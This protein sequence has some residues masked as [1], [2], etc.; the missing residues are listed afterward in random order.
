MRPLCSAVLECITRWAHQSVAREALQNPLEVR[1]CLGELAERSAR[2]C[3]PMQGLDVIG[4]QKQRRVRTRL[5]DRWTPNEGSSLTRLLEARNAFFRSSQ[6][7][8]HSA[9][10]STSVV[11]S[12]DRNATSFGAAALPGR[13][14][15]ARRAGRAR[16]ACW[17]A[18]ALRYAA[19]RLANTAALEGS[20]S[21]LRL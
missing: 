5:L 17:L 20:S 21:R 15:G 2:V 1:L 13:P 19:A 16:T 9:R 12:S 10:T 4:V 18:P 11:H 7:S 14:H 8:A 3:T 6:C